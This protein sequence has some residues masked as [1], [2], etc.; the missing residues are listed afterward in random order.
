MVVDDEGKRI[1]QDTEGGDQDETEHLGGAIPL[2]G[3]L[4]IDD[5]ADDEEGEED[6][7]GDGGYDGLVDQADGRG[8]VDLGVVLGVHKIGTDAGI[9]VRL[10]ICLLYTSPSPRDRG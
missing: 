8:V 3:G 1:G 5:E 4:A 2:R 10:V 7:E 6:A 9:D